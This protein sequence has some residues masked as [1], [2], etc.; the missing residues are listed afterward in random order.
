MPFLLKVFVI[1]SPIFILT[2]CL[3]SLTLNETGRTVG[4]GNHEISIAAGVPYA[5]AIKW[6]YGLTENFDF[7]LK[8]ESL[9]QSFR[10][11]Y[12]LIQGSSVDSGALAIAGGAGI[13]DGGKSKHY[14]GDIIAS[15]LGSSW[16]PYA[17]LRLGYVDAKTDIKSDNYPSFIISLTENLAAGRTTYAYGQTFLG[18]R[19]WFSKSTFLSL[20]G[21]YLFVFDEKG[22]IEPS[23]AATGG[24]ALGFRF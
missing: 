16:E 1:L 6:N 21:A 7:G 11:K 14:Y 24:I 22:N 2:S 9:T 3:S 18:T 5:Y 20:E 8:L 12:A 15:A 13:G 19:Y 23:G 17:A 4:K 10:L